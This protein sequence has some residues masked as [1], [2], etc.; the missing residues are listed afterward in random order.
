ME[1]ER[2]PR[3]QI[4]GVRRFNRTVTQRVGA[5]NDAYLSRDRPLGLAR[6]LWEI[7]DGAEVRVLR[8]RLGLDSGYLSRQLRRLEADGLVTTDTGPGD[9]RVR[10]VRP[11]PAGTAEQAVLDL[12][13]D[14]LAASILEPLD[15]ARRERLVAAMG[16]VERLLLSAQV[17]IGA[18]DPRG[19]DARFC[20]RSYFAELERRF[21]TGFDPG[22]SISASDEEMSPPRGLL[23]VA[24]LHGAPV[25]CGALKL[26]PGTST[27]EV[28]RMWTAPE[29][30]GLGLGRRLLE[31]MEEEAAG[32]GIR[33]LR[34]ET[35]RTLTEAIGL[36][37][38]AGFTEVDAFNDEPYAH[39]WFEKALR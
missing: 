21:E 7:A 2:I 23:L 30:R 13:S 9:G 18:A 1:A 17:R 5:L 36:Y 39:L 28:K 32:R 29:V 37:R 20:L 27:A 14:D 38:G 24:T 3:D 10:R 25:G 8:S 34:L 22:R 16:E 26:H 31:R 4:D 35:N 11:T 6:L 19:S 12:A 33:T 15:P